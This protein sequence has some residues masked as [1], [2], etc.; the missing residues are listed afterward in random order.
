MKQGKKKMPMRMKVKIIYAAFL[1]MLVLC[2][3]GIWV[4]TRNPA[5]GVLIV[6]CDA[7]GE[8]F[9]VRYVLKNWRCPHCGRDMPGV[10]YCKYC[11]QNLDDETEE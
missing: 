3:I 11:G 2:G 5:L 10:Q 1:A 7:I 6:V 8:F 9:W 4:F